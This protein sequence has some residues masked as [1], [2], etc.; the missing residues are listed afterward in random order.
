MS[1]K[2]EGGSPGNRKGSSRAVTPAPE[3][4]VKNGRFQFGTFN[5]PFTFVNMLE[6]PGIW[7]VPVPAWFKRFRLKE[8]EAFQIGNGDVFVLGAV[9]NIRWKRLLVLVVHDI[10]SGT[11]T[12]YFMECVPFRIRIGNGMKGS[13]S[14]CRAGRAHL[15][16][17]NRL[18]ENLIDLKGDIPGTAERPPVKLNVRCRHVTEPIVICQPFAENRALYSH[19][20]L[21][22]VTGDLIVGDRRILF[23]EDDAF[24]IIDDHKGFYP[25]RMA[26]DWVTGA[27]RSPEEGLLGFNLTRNQVLHP[28]K[29]NENCLWMDGKMIPLPPVFFSRIREGG[30]EVWSVRDAAGFV[31]VDFHPRGVEITERRNFLIARID[32]RAPFGR[33][34]GWIRPGGGRRIS[35][36][37]C[38]GMG[39]RK[40]MRL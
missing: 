28:E 27:V 3:S 6:G 22:P 8:W 32:Y 17:E 19:K 37:S 39:E 9:Y 5:T 31:N 11:G 2:P 14:E 20:A 24:A 4:P 33:F 13:V 26:F 21:M 35:V 18:A 23:G 12:Q 34:S 25:Y 30:R 40:R 1:G 38:F 7:P 29:Y 10:P 16:I 36:D 15:R